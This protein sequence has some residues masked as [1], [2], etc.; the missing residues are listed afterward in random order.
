MCDHL[1]VGRELV[2]AKLEKLGDGGVLVL[3]RGPTGLDRGQ[4][5]DRVGAA[6]L[7]IALSEQPQQVAHREEATG[8]TAQLPAPGQVLRQV[9]QL[10]HGER[11]PDELRYPAEPG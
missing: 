3:I 2:Q 10:L 8:R 1:D 5:A 7:A 4:S 6:L 11:G 9:V